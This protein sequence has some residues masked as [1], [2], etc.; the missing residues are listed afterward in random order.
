[1][2]ERAATSI[3]RSDGCHIEHSGVLL[4]NHQ[5]VTSWLLTFSRTSQG[6]W[7]S[8]WW[9]EGQKV[10]KKRVMF[11][12]Q[13]FFFFLNLPSLLD[14]L[15]EHPS[16]SLSDITLFREGGTA[17][18]D[19]LPL[20]GESGPSSVRGFT[21]K[22]V[23]HS[24]NYTKLK[25]N[26]VTSFSNQIIYQCSCCCCWSWA[27]VGWWAGQ[28]GQAWSPVGLVV[29]DWPVHLENW[30]KKQLWHEDPVLACYCHAVGSSPEKWRQFYSWFHWETCCLELLTE[31]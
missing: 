7:P 24:R 29:L 30:R 9:K 1:M 14:L 5:T 19:P 13:G 27:S 23:N 11:K 26:H 2:T 10:T 18:A 12:C 6:I 20:L 3:L 15:A 21:I 16:L 22:L 31:I 8:Y 28:P 25:H 17:L 4:N